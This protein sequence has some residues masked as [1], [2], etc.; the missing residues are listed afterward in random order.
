ME[1]LQ[2]IFPI[3]QIRIRVD[4]HTYLIDS[5]IQEKS[6]IRIKQL[7]CEDFIEFSRDATCIQRWLAQKLK[8]E[9]LP[10]I[11]SVY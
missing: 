11:L 7:L 9:N 5:R 2:V 3:C 10:H 6:E 4:L 1:V 8:T